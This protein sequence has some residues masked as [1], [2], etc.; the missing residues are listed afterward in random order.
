M[1]YKVMVTRVQVAE[2]W[3][4]ATDEEDAAKKVQ[5]EFNRRTATSAP[6]KTWHR[7]S[8]WSKLSRRR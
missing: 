1:R 7:K 3:V 5:E 8:K 2:R 4:R 6:G